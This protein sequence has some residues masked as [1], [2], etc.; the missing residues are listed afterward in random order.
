MLL[1]DYREGEG[2]MQ[3]QIKTVLWLK[4]KIYILYRQE[5]N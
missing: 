4:K 2:L 1:N 3:N 5:L